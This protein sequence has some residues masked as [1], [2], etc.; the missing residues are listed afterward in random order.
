MGESLKITALTLNRKKKADT[1]TTGLL[2]DRACC[3]PRANTRSNP[4]V[5]TPPKIRNLVKLTGSVTE[6]VIRN[7]DTEGTPNIKSLEI[8]AWY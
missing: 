3:L 6:P 2:T 4:A 7:I 5:P 8:V 1:H